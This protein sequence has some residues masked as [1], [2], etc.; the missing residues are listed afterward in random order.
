MRTLTIALILQAAH[1]RRS[2]VSDIEN[3]ST[4]SAESDSSAMDEDSDFVPAPAPD[5]LPS[6]SGPLL[7]GSPI[8]IENQYKWKPS[9]S[10]WALTRNEIPVFNPFSSKWAVTR[11]L[12]PVFTR[13]FGQMTTLAGVWELRPRFFSEDGHVNYGDEVVIENQYAGRFLLERNPFSDGEPVFTTNPERI[14]TLYAVWKIRSY[15]GNLS[16]KVD[17]N[18]EVLLENQF[19]DGWLLGRNMTPIFTT[20]RASVI[21]GHARWK[22]RPVCGSM[23]VSG[24]WVPRQFFHSP[25]GVTK[26]TIRVGVKDRN[27]ISHTETWEASLSASVTAGYDAGVIAQPQVSVQVT[28]LY[29]WGG[30]SAV[31]RA[32]E[33]EWSNE[34]TISPTVSGLL[35]QFSFY[36]SSP[37]GDSTVDT[38][39]YVVTE[40]EDNK[41]CCPPGLFADADKPHGPCIERS[42]CMCDKEVCSG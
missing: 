31:A 3:S 13:D 22:L 10:K 20:D 11:I 40:S 6:C 12:I 5:H 32:L 30:S 27:S 33:Q 37:C 29:A 24:L 15:P 4:I 16:G 1:G 26:T 2:R 19:S 35:W 23:R 34:T 14:R 18:S 9:S 36:A 7:Y 8:E 42:L 17:C 39:S 28:G 41:P 38:D 21:D 25:A